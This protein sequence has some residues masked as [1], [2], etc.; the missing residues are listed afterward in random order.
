[1]QIFICKR[2]ETAFSHFPVCMGCVAF[3]QRME[4]IQR[5]SQFGRKKTG[6]K[7][8]YFCHGFV[9]S[10]VAAVDCP[11]DFS[12]SGSFRPDKKEDHLCL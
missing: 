11:N 9:D 4:S 5:K 7:V 12:I 10:V 1:M 6:F 2:V 3:I 8:F